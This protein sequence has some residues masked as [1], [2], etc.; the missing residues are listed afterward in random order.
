MHGH[1]VTVEVGVERRADQ[2]MQ[3]NRLALDQH[4]LKGLNAQTV[5]CRSTVEQNGML[6]DNFF[7]NVPHFRTFFL[8]HFLGRLDGGD[9]STLFKFVVDERLEQLEGHL[10]R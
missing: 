7:E 4:G 1:L 3:L 8:D 10:L 6:F 9:E 5:Q 2:R